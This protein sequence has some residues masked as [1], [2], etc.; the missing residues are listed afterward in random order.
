M[1]HAPHGSPDN[2]LHD[3]PPAPGGV[4]E[5]ALASRG[6][7]WLAT[8][9]P[10]QRA[11]VETSDCAGRVLAGAALQHLPDDDLIHLVGRHAG[12]GQ[13]G[14]QRVR[15]QPRVHRQARQVDVHAAQGLRL[16]QEPGVVVRQL[17]GHGNDVTLFVSF[18]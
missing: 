13:R 6:A 1:P 12:P 2:G 4:R 17:L 7:P 3:D 11:A 10:E 9:N 14:L 5:R 16:A 18:E 15:A 8:L